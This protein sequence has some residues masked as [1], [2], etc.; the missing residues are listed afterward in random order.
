MIWDVGE[1]LPRQFEHWVSD[2]G[3][4]DGQMVF[5]NVVRICADWPPSVFPAFWCFWK[6][7]LADWNMH[8]YWKVYW[9]EH[10][11]R[12]PFCLLSLNCFFSNRS[13]SML[14][15]EAVVASQSPC[16]DVGSPHRR[17]SRSVTVFCPWYGL[18]VPW[19][20]KS[21]SKISRANLGT[22]SSVIA[23]IAPMNP[24]RSDTPLMLGTSW[25]KSGTL[26]LWKHKGK[27]FKPL[28]GIS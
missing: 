24:C 3:Q 8:S 22:T 9:C 2:M 19:L 27:N 10:K 7:G 15:Y 18:L 14:E 17:T 23:R 6:R 4:A 25:E 20:A 5:E 12:H 16:C 11:F 13:C 26:K 1:L 21:D 28:G